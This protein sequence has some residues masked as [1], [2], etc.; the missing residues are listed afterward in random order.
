MGDFFFLISSL[1]FIGQADLQSVVIAQEVVSLGGLFAFD[2]GIFIFIYSF[3]YKQLFL[4]SL[5][6]ILMEQSIIPLLSPSFPP[7]PHPLAFGIGTYD[8]G[9][10]LCLGNCE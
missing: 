10:F 5:F 8:G 1:G 4:I 3:G 9:H 2:K 6:A 7:F